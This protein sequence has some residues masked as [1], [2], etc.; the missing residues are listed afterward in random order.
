MK[1]TVGALSEKT[2][3]L[4]IML[5]ASGGTM[6]MQNHP[7]LEYQIK[8]VFLYN[9]TQFVEWPDDAFAT[10]DSPLVIGILGSDPF[11]QYLDNTIV[12]EAGNGH[13][14]VVERYEEVEDIAACHIL[15]INIAD[16]RKLQNVLS[17]L[18]GRN[19]LTISDVQH[20]A[21]SGGILQ[22]FEERNKIRLRINLEAAK[23]ADLNISSKLLSLAEVTI[24]QK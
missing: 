14:L 11:G 21:R 5:I 16:K 22:F 7:A 4:A 15:F 24:I 10:A 2:L 6:P 13:P 9:F 12:G 18:E 23:S 8:A 3:I 17:D 1:I 19:I 20:F